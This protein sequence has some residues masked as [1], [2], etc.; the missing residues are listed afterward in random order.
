MNIYLSEQLKKLRKEKG[1]TQEDLAIHLGITTQAVSKWEREEGYP[2]I[3]LLP[4]IASYYNVTIDDLLGV[5]Q[6]EKENKLREY[7]RKNTELYRLGKNADR[8]ALW[9]EAIKEFPNDLTVLCELMNALYVTDCVG[10][11]DEIIE[12]GQRII[13]ESTD[14]AARGSAV[15]KLSFTYYYA[16][17]DAESAKKYAKMVPIYSVTV[18]QIMPKLLEGREAVEYCQTN[19]E[20]L[21]DLVGNNVLLMCKKG[22]YSPEDTIK[23]CRFVLDC[24]D[25]L[26]PDGICGFYHCRYAEFYQKMAENYLMMDDVQNMHDCLAKAAEH[27]VKYDTL[28]DGEFI[29]FMLKGVTY[30]GNDGVKSHTENCAGL[31]LKFLQRESFA[32]FTDDPRMLKIKTE[33]QAVAI[34]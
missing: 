17:K 4:S 18:N 32:P 7:W 10:Y 27:A 19:I 1:N 23:A 24:V 13:D 15:Q 8:V 30:S 9:R 26:Y 31:L 16:K 25:L 20:Y 28:Q 34:M 29:S 14:C 12:Y 2:D 11:A 3:T 22:D 6:V 21:F 5:G 33:L